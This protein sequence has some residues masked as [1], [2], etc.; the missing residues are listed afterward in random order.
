MTFFGP[1]STMNSNA[2]DFV[3][4][5]FNTTGPHLQDNISS[6]FSEYS[7]QVHATSVFDQ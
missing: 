2:P 1:T 4:K 6:W 5:L 7:S 3:S